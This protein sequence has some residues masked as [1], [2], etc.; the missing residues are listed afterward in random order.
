[1]STWQWALELH[2]V[3][4]WVSSSSIL[5]DLHRQERGGTQNSYKPSQ[6]QLIRPGLHKEPHSFR[7]IW[8]QWNKKETSLGRPMYPSWHVLSAPGFVTQAKLQGMHK[9]TSFSPVSQNS[10]SLV[11]SV[12]FFLKEVCATSQSYPKS[13][14]EA[15]PDRRSSCNRTFM[16]TCTVTDLY[17]SRRYKL[18]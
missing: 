5:I 18:L 15:V 3:W 10:D 6:A 17:Q 1:M 14:W 4:V 7:E 2:A 13:T 12:T 16:D 9:Q 11:H 8:K